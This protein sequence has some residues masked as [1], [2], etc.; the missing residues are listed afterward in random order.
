MK[1]VNNDHNEKS[2]KKKW[3]IDII[4]KKRILL[5]VYINR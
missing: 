3:V 4:N 2:N 1:K 5:T